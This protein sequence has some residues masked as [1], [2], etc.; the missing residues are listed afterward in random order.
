MQTTRFE[1]TVVEEGVDFADV[2]V[3]PLLAIGAE[4]FV[5]ESI[6]DFFLQAGHD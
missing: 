5:G 2:R 1:I 3:R 6:V 4:G